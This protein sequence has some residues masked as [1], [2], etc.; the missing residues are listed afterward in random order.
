MDSN[1]DLALN[2]A[3]LQ[4]LGYSESSPPRLGKDVL[5]LAL[6]TIRQKETTNANLQAPSDKKP[7]FVD[8]ALVRA[9][10][11]PAPAV[12]F[13]QAGV[14]VGKVCGEAR[15]NSVMSLPTYVAHKTGVGHLSIF[16]NAKRAR[17]GCELQWHR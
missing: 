1:Y 16:A 14:H 7:L 8:D 15:W 13:G 12:A 11:T 17:A 4:Q 2:N 10:Q 6:L 5:C 3:D 9:D